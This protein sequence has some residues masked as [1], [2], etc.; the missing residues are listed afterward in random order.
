MTRKPTANGQQPTVRRPSLS[1]VS[2]RPSAQG[3][4]TLLEVMVALAILAVS[5]T[6]LVEATT[7]AI[8]AEN[9]AKLVSAATFLARARLVEL[10]DELAEKGFTDDS[11]AKE[12]SGDFEDKG[13]KRFRWTTVIDK[14]ELP[15]T[16]QVQ[17][18][19]TKGLETQASSTLGSLG[20][21]PPT[22]PTGGG[23]AGGAPQLGGGSGMLASQF[24]IIKDVLEQSIRRARVR[25]GWNEGRSEQSMEITEYLTDP[26]RVDQSIQLGGL[27]G[28][29]AAGTPGAPGGPGSAGSGSSSGGGSSGAPPSGPVPSIGGSPGGGSAGFGVR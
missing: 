9:H 16:D 5:L 18:L 10:E 25:I 13:F 29:G 11:F 14:I 1:A 8:A 28:G 23:G 22:L 24:G 26:K 27:A 4:F 20:G 19:V 15:N 7:R 21:T 6:W 3:G 2:C 17:S 12:T